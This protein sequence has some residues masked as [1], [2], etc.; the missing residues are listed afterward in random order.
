[1]AAGAGGLAQADIEARVVEARAKGLLPALHFSA[2][3]VDGTVLWKAQAYVVRYRAGGFMV[4]VPGDAEVADFFEM[5]GPFDFYAHHQT[6]V[7]MEN[8]RGRALGTVDAV[9]VD[10]PWSALQFFKRASSLRGEAALARL[11]FVHDGVT[12]RPS[13]EGA[14]FAAEAWI[15]E[16]MDEEAAGEYMSCEE[17]I[18]V[19]AEAATAADPGQVHSVEQLQAH[20]QDLEVQLA[21]LAQQRAAPAIHPPSQPAHGLLGAMPKAAGV[22]AQTMER[23]R[24]LAGAGPPRLGGHERR[25]RALGLTPNEGDAFET[26]QQE[27]EL[28]ATDGDELAQLT[29]DAFPDPMQKLLFLPMQQVTL[30]QKQV[31][32]RQPQDAIHAALSSGNENPG[33][34]SSGIK[35]CLAR[36][37]FLKI[38]DN[39]VSIAQVVE[40][41]ALM[42]LG[43]N[44]SQ[45]SPGLLR[46]YLEKRVPLGSFRLLTQVGYLMASAYEMGQRTGNRE[47]AGFGAKG[48]IFVEQ[49]ALDEGKTSL[50]WLLTGLPEPNFSQVQMPRARS[51][52]KPFSRLCNP[53]WVAANVGYLRDL[54]FLESKIRHTD[55]D[56]TV[57]AAKAQ[58]DAPVPKKPWPKKKN[59]GKE[60]GGGTAESAE[61][62]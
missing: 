43:L 45:L 50:S 51:S 31:A 16:T 49:T 25:D 15:A 14:L 27:Q 22:P 3:A 32:A 13:R 33:S 44:A 11:K 24:S 56:A 34:S 1:M 36:E 28:G 37:A 23:L 20:I 60:G 46:D 19:E 57:P 40:N 10:C 54:D 59:K 12:C 58:V 48:L 29:V 62:V 26:F 35:G 21:S 42:E 9:L 2:T 38:S 17:A 52:L 6:S 8:A 53:S 18:V 30:L 39:L 4:L 55:K 7:Q 41:N 5:A 61:A 47:V